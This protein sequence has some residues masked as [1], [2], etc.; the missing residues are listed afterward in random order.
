MKKHNFNAGPSILP[1]EVIGN[2]ARAILDFNGS[3]LSVLSIS[4]RTKDFDDVMAEADKLFRELLAIPD[5]YKIFYLGGGATA[6]FSTRSPPTSS[7]ARPVT[8]IPASGPRRPSRRPSVTARSRS[9]LRPRTAISLT[10]LRVSPFPPTS[11]ICTS[12]PT[13]P[14]TAPSSTRIFRRPCLS[15]PTCRP[16]SSRVRSTSPSTL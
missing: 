4:H 7:A 9:S 5:N 16:T 8:S 15:S 11:I 6:P 13:I 1:E 3:G 12:P 14:S 2:A 10:F